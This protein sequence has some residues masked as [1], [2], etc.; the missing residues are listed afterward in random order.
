M[1]GLFT[2]T[3]NNKNGYPISMIT[4]LVISDEGVNNYLNWAPQRSI[5]GALN[6]SGGELEYW[7][8]TLI[9]D[10]NSFLINIKTGTVSEDIKKQYSAEVRFLRALTY[11]EMVKR[12]GGVPIILVPQNIN[13]G[14]ALFV[15]R[16]KEK[17]V[18]ELIRKECDT[19]SAI[20]PE[21]Y[22]SSDMGRITKYA[23]LALKSRAMLYAASIAKYS[24]VQLDGI[25]G[26]PAS[27]A[28]TYWEASLD[29][30][31]AIMAAHKFVLYDE[32]PEEKAKNYQMIFLDE[33][34]EEIILAKKFIGKL[35]GH[36]FDDYTQPNFNYTYWGCCF[37][38][39]LEL[40]DA[41]EM[42][43][44][45]SGVID[46]PNVQGQQREI[47]KNKDPRFEASIMYNGQQWAWDTCR[48]WKGIYTETGELRNSETELY[49]GMDEVG[50]DQKTTQGPLTGFLLKKF[51][52]PVLVFP[53]V[54][55]SGQDWI[56]FRYAEVLLNYAEASFELGQTANALDA[57]NEI[58]TR[59]GIASLG[60]VTLDQ[61]RHERRIELVF[62][63]HRFWDIR[64]WRIAD[65]FMGK[66][67]S[68]A[69]PYY[70]FATNQF[71]YEV[72][73]TEFFDRVWKQEYYYYPINESRRN[74]NPNLIE[75]PGYN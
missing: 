47:F 2:Q 4:Q 26:I 1:S 36:T 51:L 72:G 27:D 65:N 9:H 7:D 67:L 54:N 15:P 68:G 33:D 13:D 17:E 59:A 34:N 14:D 37:S 32:Y 35:Y 40:V 18:Y 75:N 52:D 29:A 55:E 31:E 60:S 73:N 39:S 3:P 71:E 69:F 70:H 21:S 12:Y 30:S 63:T 46:W 25:V 23:A 58:R 6:A 61:I 44:G 66:N 8:Y 41:F 24:T 28:D 53:L 38:P 43:D 45:S 20:L 5:S 57:I 74:N 64:R 19:I 62:E 42:K 10:I 49:N 48:I 56:L 11:F 50:R 16:N 22:S